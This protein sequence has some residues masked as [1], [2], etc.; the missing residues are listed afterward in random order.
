MDEVGCAPCTTKGFGFIGV[1][2]SGFVR[3]LA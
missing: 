1:E 2:L 3:V